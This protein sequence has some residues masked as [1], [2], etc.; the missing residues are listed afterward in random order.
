MALLDT[1]RAGV[2]TLNKITR[3]GKLQTA[4]SYQ[5]VTARDAYG[6]AS[7]FSSPV[8][9]KA[10]IDFTGR[11]VRNKEGI[12]VMATATLTFLSVSEVAAAT[13]N[14]GVDEDDQFT[15]ANGRVSKVVSIGGFM[16]SITYGPIPLTVYLG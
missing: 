14:A 2:E 11:P 5:R 1:L 13:N 3:T 7:A 8:P 9:L 10:I 4:V 16:D 15:L 12:T 6:A